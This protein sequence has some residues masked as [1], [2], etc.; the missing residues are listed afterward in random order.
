MKQKKR[1]SIRNLF[2][3]TQVGLE[4]MTSAVTGQRSNQLSYWAKK[5]KNLRFLT[6]TVVCVANDESGT[7]RSGVFFPHRVLCDGGCAS[8]G[9]F[10]AASFA[11]GAKFIFPSRHSKIYLYFLI[12]SRYFR[13]LLPAPLL[14]LVCYLILCYSYHIRVS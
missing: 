8:G 14:N 6:A 7:K 4:P 3:A 9:L 12:L 2:R 10:R 13:Q 11:A 1:D 5:I